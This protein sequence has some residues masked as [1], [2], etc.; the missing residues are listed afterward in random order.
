MP[1][2]PLI[3][4][5]VFAAIPGGFTTPTPAPLPIVGGTDA[6]TCEYP[7]AV[8]MLEDDETP[9]MCSGSL[10][11]PDVVLT[12]A[13]CLIPERPIVAIGF[14]EA[15]QVF[16]EPAFTVAPESC[17]QH[18]DYA[19][20]GTTDIAYC[21]L[22]EPVTNV[23]I[24]PL[25]AGCEVDVLQPGQAVTIV[26]FGATWGTYD[27]QTE[28]LM[29]MGVG[30]KRYT[31]Q[32]IDSVD[33]DVVEVN[34]LGPNGSQSA[35]FGDSG[36]PAMV[37]LA[38]GTWRVFGAGSHL[39]DPGG[40]P[41][42]MQEG[43]ICGVGVAYSYATPTIEWLEA[44]TGVDL[45]PCW[46]GD[47]FVEGCGESPT[48]PGTASGSWDDGC[49]GGAVGGGAA[50]CMAA[51]ETGTDG[52][53]SSDDGADGTEGSSSGAAESGTTTTIDPTTG[54]DGSSGTPADGSGDASA[55]TTGATSS[56]G[57]SSGSTGDGTNE[58]GDGGGGCG[59]VAAPGSGAPWLLT[60]AVARRRRRR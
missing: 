22:A 51:G 15:G 18:P 41:P 52:G 44:Q 16:G 38:D 20:F 8:A 24:V 7:S 5:F 50:T 29:T 12:A 53:S 17:E 56:P 46:D 10:V 39:F 54:D 11:A 13:H 26:G 55:G 58:A 57:E 49:A 25:L 23:P 32:T 14:G 1:F 19:A 3:P 35:C 2:G 60:I 33:L 21:K 27:E 36:G 43:N 28:S 48:A 40:Q 9:V 47:A 37:E 30:A 4:C 59:C 31:T 34:M 6:V 42:P 45:T